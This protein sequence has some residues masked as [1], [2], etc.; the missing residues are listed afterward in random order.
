VRG[1]N[2]CPLGA[3]RWFGSERSVTV[4]IEE[5][6]VLSKGCGQQGLIPFWV[7]CEVVHLGVYVCVDTYEFKWQGSD[8]VFKYQIMSHMC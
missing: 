7:W 6:A 4:E 5:S 2:G 3:T 1:V 8:D